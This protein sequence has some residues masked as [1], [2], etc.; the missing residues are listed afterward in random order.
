MCCIAVKFLKDIGFV[1]AKCRDR[2]YPFFIKIINSNRDSIQRLYIDDQT[3]RWT[4]G[5]NETGLSIISASFS[6]ADDE[7]EGKKI[8]LKKKTKKPIIS[9]DGLAIRNALLLK[10]PKKAA[11][12]LIN[13][14]LAGATF[15]FNRDICYLLEGGFTIRKKKATKD[16][17]RD[18][19]YNL[20]EITKEA[21]YAVRT[22]HGIDMP[23]LGY[24]KDS[25][26]PYIKKC[27]ESSES[28]WKIVNNYLRDNDITNPKGLLDA[29][30]QSPSKDPFMNPIRTGDPKKGDMVTTGTL[31][32]VPAESTLHYT[33]IY[34][35]V[36]FCYHKLS[37]EKNKTFFEIISN[38]KL[39]SFKDFVKK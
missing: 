21:N 10:D 23:M 4:E 13:K 20:K 3:T 19:I 17:P 27:R 16:Y 34:S 31:L 12:Y 7:K 35:S 28:R 8:L 29:L 15:I 5:L 22:N 36:E 18:Y 2:N 37:N 9:P 14:Q 38:R 32:V 24:V 33:P 11:E 6:V 1:G 26:D 39:L 25:K 30:N